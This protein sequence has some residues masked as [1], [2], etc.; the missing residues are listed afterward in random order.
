MN[1]TELI[2]ETN[3]KLAVDFGA[4][5]RWFAAPTLLRS[6]HPANGGWS[7]DQILEH[8]ALTN[9]Y[10]LILIE[11]GA[12]K[13]LKNAHGLD[14][15]TEL[16]NRQSVRAHLDEI[17]R[18]G[19]FTWMRPAHME[20]RG[21][22]TGPEVAATLHQQLQQCQAVLAR[23]PHGEGVLYR[24]TMSVHDLGK[25]DVYDFVYFLAKHAE[26]HVTQIEK[27]AEEYRVQKG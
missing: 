16:A 22:K 19:A 27:V 4:L 8:V 3:Q 18:P 25:L 12:T 6:Y 9:H 2:A 17:G 26:R 21:L 7:V 13:A 20:P 15:A 11:K 14:L 24:T 10:L 5:D 1:P 23:L